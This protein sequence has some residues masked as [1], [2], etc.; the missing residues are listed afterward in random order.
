MIL[1]IKNQIKEP[2][3]IPHPEK[4]PELEPILDPETPVLYPDENP[5]EKPEEESVQDPPYQF[6]KPSELP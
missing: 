6:P 4:L 2:L 3:T 5:L 1:E